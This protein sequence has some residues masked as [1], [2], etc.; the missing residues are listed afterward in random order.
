MDLRHPVIL[1]S[2]DVI[3]CHVRI[4]RALL[5]KMT[6]NDKISYGSLPPCSVD[7]MSHVRIQRARLR[8]YTHGCFCS[9][10]I[11]VTHLNFDT[12]FQRDT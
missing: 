2:P 7:L 11:S 5:Q 12:V 3:T 10:E 1:I 4:H 6:Y 9:F 8:I